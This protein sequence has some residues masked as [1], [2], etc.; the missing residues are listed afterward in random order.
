MNY[1]HG[2]AQI[3]AILPKLYYYCYSFIPNGYYL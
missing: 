2:I 1:A 3:A